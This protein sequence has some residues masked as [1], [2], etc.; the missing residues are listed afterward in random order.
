MLKGLQIS[1][2]LKLIYLAISLAI[3]KKKTAIFSN[4]SGKNSAIVIGVLDFSNRLFFA[5]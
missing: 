4:F 3:L 5:I 1:I 2:L